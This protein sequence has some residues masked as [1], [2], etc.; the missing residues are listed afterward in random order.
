MADWDECTISLTSTGGRERRAIPLSDEVAAS[1]SAC[2]RCRTDKRDRDPY[3][4]PA[5]IFSCKEIDMD[6]KMSGL[7]RTR[8]ATTLI[9]CALAVPAGAQQLNT[10]RLAKQTTNAASCADVVWARTALALY[11]RISEACQ[12]IVISDGV[13]WA[14]FDADLVRQGQGNA[15]LNFRDRD[16]RSMQEVT[17]K[18]GSEQRALIEGR[19]YSLAGLPLGQRLTVYVPE[20][21]FAAAAVT[22]AASPTL[23]APRSSR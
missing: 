17:L 2:V 4:S 21:M 13:K 1:R 3:T 6:T 22:P 8:I 7:R 12:E 10:D 14:R 9:A 5:N 20:R 23:E 19:S 15:T 18:P 16:G 11:P